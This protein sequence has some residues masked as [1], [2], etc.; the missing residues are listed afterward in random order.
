MLT[1][2]MKDVSICPLESCPALYCGMQEYE[3][4]WTIIRRG[5]IISFL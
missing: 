4:V 3:E 1:M 5:E 2:Y